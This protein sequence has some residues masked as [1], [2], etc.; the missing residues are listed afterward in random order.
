VPLSQ[1]GLGRVA[2]GGNAADASSWDMVEFTAG[3]TSP[4][5][6][7]RCGTFAVREEKAGG[8]ET[9]TKNGCAKPRVWRLAALGTM[10]AAF[11]RRSI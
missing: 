5:P 8:M 11:C 7:S 4:F 9:S 2:V 3:K 1:A 10:M 6:I